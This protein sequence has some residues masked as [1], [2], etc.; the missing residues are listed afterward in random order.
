MTPEQI[1]D[2]TRLEKKYSFDSIVMFRGLASAYIA[3]DKQFVTAL[4]E[5]RKAEGEL[6]AQVGYPRSPFA[7]YP[8]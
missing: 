4:K 5:R 2:L 6:A 3:R 8:V 7:S 1:E